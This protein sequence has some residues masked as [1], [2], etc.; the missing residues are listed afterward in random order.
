MM[1]N[2]LT[3]RSP[4]R[5]CSTTRTIAK[6]MNNAPALAPAERRFEFGANWTRFL[7]VL[8]DE[9]ISHAKLSLQTMLD[10]DS[11]A[12]KTFL[13]VG[14]GS[15]LFSLAA[16]SLGARVHSFDYDQASCGCALQLKT[17]YFAEDENW[18]IE[19]GS[20]LDRS[21]VER[22]GKFDIVY[23]WG[24]L[25]H[26]G[27]MW[28]AVENASSLVRSGGTLFI[29]IYNDQGWVSR[30]WKG[31]KDLYCSGIFGRWLVKCAYYPYFMLSG[32]VADLVR[33]RNPIAR[34]TEY[35][36][37]RGMSAIHDWADWLGGNPFEV[38]KP[39]DVIHFCIARGFQLR[40]LKTCGGRLGCNE[41]VL[42]LGD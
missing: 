37:R 33:R 32:F 1:L 36:K 11:L 26:T 15:G 10:V 6:S 9:R 19:Q 21:L 14:S 4:V 29:A 25:H 18:T 17:R 30:W 3:R 41:F 13:D 12:G 27:Q 8:D 20:I 2:Y 28:N 38:A 22:L 42:V 31:V 5:R 23:S 39:E 24:V 40:K 35:K 34:Y 16:R 7:R